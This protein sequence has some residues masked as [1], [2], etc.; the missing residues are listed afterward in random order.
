MQ[1]GM[2]NIIAIDFET[3]LGDSGSLKFY[4]PDFRATSCAFAWRNSLGVMK[5]HYVEGEDKIREALITLQNKGKKLLAHNSQFECSVLMSRFPE[6]DINLL[7]YDSQ[8]LAFFFDGGGKE[9][10]K[11]GGV[12]IERTVSVD[13]EH[14]FVIESLDDEADEELFYA[15]L[16]LMGCCNRILP[17]KVP[18]MKRKVAEYLAAAHSIPK[19]DYGSHLNKLP[20]L[21]M[22]EYNTSDSIYAYMLFEFL[23]AKLAEQKADW[24][25]DHRDHIRT[26]PILQR[27]TMRGVPVERVGLQSHLEV[28]TAEVDKIKGDFKIKY[29]NEIAQVEKR[30][31]EKMINKLKTEKGREK[32]RAN[33]EQWRDDWQFKLTSTQQLSHIFVDL[34]GIKPRFFTKKGKK[35]SKLKEFVP[36]PSFK[37]SHLP[38]YGDGGKML[39]KLK[40]RQLVVSQ[41]TNLL[42]LSKEDGRWHLGLRATGPKTGRYAGTSFE[43]V[44]LNAQ[45]LARKE[46]GLMSCLVV[47]DPENCEFCS[48]DLK[49]GEPTIIANFSR[50][51]NYIKIARDMNGVKPY[52]DEQ[53]ILITNDFYVTYMSLSPITRDLIRKMWDDGIFEKWVETDGKCVTDYI[54]K[55][56]VIINGEPAEKITLKFSDKRTD[57]KILFLMTNYGCSFKKAQE[58]MAERNNDLSAKDAKRMIENYW[59]VLFP[60]VGKLRDRLIMVIEKTGWLITPFGF[61]V[62]PDEARLAY[63]YT[64]QSSVSVIMKELV[65]Y[66]QSLIDKGEFDAELVTIIHDELIYR[67]RKDQ[68]DRFYA[69]LQGKA[70]EITKRLK[71][72]C[73][74]QLGC[75]K[76]SNLYTAK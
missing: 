30:N 32:K 10:Q 46:K 34:M 18:D 8:R 28:V 64:I 39:A 35:T 50:D 16:S 76:G 43:D 70:D 36:K 69:A 24:R 27:A 61:R 3:V 15:P 1:A 29:A 57:H 52:W 22:E 67:I 55:E 42:A 58:S 38:T 56:D 59:R 37:S 68:T 51:K 7:Q 65:V 21:L 31:Q 45:G 74:I 33:I 44:K 49:A 40:K 60:E 72:V 26:L 48:F 20:S 9:Y 4:S 6:V 41:S 73:P 53:G 5:T 14:E 2:E 47:E 62:C 75:K 63:N 23:T 66:M 54:E 17:H 13:I 12:K 71:W 19:K 11:N 25:P